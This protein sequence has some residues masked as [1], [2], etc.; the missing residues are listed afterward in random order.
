MHAD[1]WPRTTVYSYFKAI[2]ELVVTGPTLMNVNDIRAI[3]IRYGGVLDQPR[4][5]RV[6]GAVPF[7]LPD[8]VKGTLF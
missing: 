4:H 5:E 6:S 7:L 1:T 2:G 3:L 8:H